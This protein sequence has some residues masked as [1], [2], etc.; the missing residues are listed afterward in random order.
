LPPANIDA[1]AVR[2]I[3]SMLGNSPAVRA[4]LTQE[5]LTNPRFLR[6]DLP[7]LA[8][9]A[10]S[11]DRPRPVWQ[12]PPPAGEPS[13]CQPLLDCRGF[14]YVAFEHEPLLVLFS[15][16][17]CRAAPLTDDAKVWLLPPPAPVETVLMHGVFDRCDPLSI[18]E[19]IRCHERYMVQG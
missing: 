14:E 3:E 11:V 2:K 13:N 18:P 6:A 15:D 5:A 17:L 16:V 7:R 12:A 10:F 4:C 8:P 9:L 1:R 19:T